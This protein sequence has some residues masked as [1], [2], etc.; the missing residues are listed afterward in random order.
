[1]DSS[2][3]QHKSLELKASTQTEGLFSGWASKYGE[4]DSYGDRIVPGAYDKTYQENHGQIVILADHDVTKAIG[5]AVLELRPEGLWVSAQLSMDLQD[6][7]DAYVRLRDGLKSGLSIG[8]TPRETDFRGSVR[9]LTDIQLFEVSVVQFPA[10]TSARVVAV[11]SGPPHADSRSDLTQL[12]D[13]LTHMRDSLDG[14]QVDPDAPV[15]GPSQSLRPTARTE[16][17]G[18][19]SYYERLDQSLREDQQ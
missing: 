17:E 14:K 16:T 4:V 7:R 11:K 3:L 12:A 15:Y 10:Q 19:Q 18:Y 1:M 9:E 13:S 8:F 5:K 6:A 2:K